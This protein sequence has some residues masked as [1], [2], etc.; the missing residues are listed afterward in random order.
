M[1]ILIGPPLDVWSLG[2]VLFA[3]LCGRMPFEGPDLSGSRRPR[4][5]VITARILKC[6]YKMDDRLG[7]EA[8]VC[9]YVIA[10]NNFHLCAALLYV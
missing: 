4:D 9:V 7:L 6:Q 3:I 2:V 8:K 1:T 5:S 10:F